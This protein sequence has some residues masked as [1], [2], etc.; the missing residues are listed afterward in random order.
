MTAADFM[1]SISRDVKANCARQHR[2]RRRRRRR[3]RSRGSSALA[4]EHGAWQEPRQRLRAV[5]MAQLDANSDKGW[6]SFAGE[7][8]ENAGGGIECAACDGVCARFGGGV[9]RR[10]TG[11]GGTKLGRGEESS[12]NKEFIWNAFSVHTVAKGGGKAALTKILYGTLFQLNMWKHV[13][14]K[15]FSKSFRLT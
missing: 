6:R 15:I 14:L 3:M 4:A 12:P 7:G 1:R 8:C 9:H 2:R 5:G 10:G 13:S 11:G